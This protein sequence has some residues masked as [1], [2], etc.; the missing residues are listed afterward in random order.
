VF[1]ADGQVSGELNRPSVAQLLD[2][3]KD[4]EC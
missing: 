2:A 1:L 4:Q 3:L